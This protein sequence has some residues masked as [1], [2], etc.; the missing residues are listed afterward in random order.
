MLP[1]GLFLVLLISFTV[2][3]DSQEIKAPSS[4]NDPLVLQGP[5]GVAEGRSVMVSTQT[6]QVTE[7]AL[8]VLRDGGNAI[9]AFIT[10]VFLQQ[11][12]EPHMVSHWGIMSGI[13]YDGKSG[14]YHHF[15]ALGERPLASRSDEGGP[16]KTAI[17]GTVRGLEALWKRFGTK[18]WP[19]YLEPAIKA[20]EEGVLV[21]SYMY[22]ILYAAW[23]NPKGQWPEGVRDIKDNKEARD[24]YM[25]NGFLVPVGER[26]KMPQVAEHLRKLAKHG[27]GYV[28][29]GKWAKEFVKQANDLGA[30]V[31]KKDLAEYE[32]RWT[33]PV[34]TTYRGYE[35][36]GQSSPT[37]GGLIIGANLNILEHFDLKS[38]G[39][40]WENAESLEIMARTMGRVDEDIAQV[41]DP[42][43]YYDPSELILSDD[44][45][46]L[47]AE[48]VRQTRL[49]PGIDLSN[50]VDA[51]ESEDS[52]ILTHDSN[53]NII[54]DSEGSWIS[55]LHSGHGGAPGV[56]IDG[57]EANGS[58]IPSGDVDG[59]GRR[60]AAPLAAIIVAKDNKPF[61][62]MGTPG[63]PPQPITEILVN[64]LEFG[65]SPRE[66]VDAPRFWADN[67]RNIRIE[68]RISEDVRKDIKAAGFK[69]KDLTDFNW[70][71]G[72]IQLVWFDSNEGKY[73]GISDPRRL[74][75]ADG[76]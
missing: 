67:K 17:G 4:A 42:L 72:S 51:R 53:H 29:R 65:L 69:I 62:A 14:E 22:G 55:S 61:M 66:A 40:Y 23:E 16:M 49:R 20:A 13:V 47:N 74:G 25:P 32:V 12:T 41:G 15:D 68:S 8:Q 27:A 2:I 28:Y 57:I 39:P 31:T 36:I 6:A 43:N 52:M 33:K 76:Y 1:K 24:F 48:F 21:T 45:S 73:F 37:T 5:K 19:Y 75:Q 63:M 3:A 35:I 46:R 26:W 71:V 38:M 9:D 30:R 10:S 70:H 18:P 54:V 60:M 11:V 58:S 50:T 59:P 64:I 44:Y 34:R 7:A 56:F